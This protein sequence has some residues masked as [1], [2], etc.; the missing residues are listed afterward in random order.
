VTTIW[1][2]GITTANNQSENPA[3]VFYRLATQDEEA[4]IKK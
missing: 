1:A 4:L 3:A 2:A